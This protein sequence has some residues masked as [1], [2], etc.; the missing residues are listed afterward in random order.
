V[1]VESVNVGSPETVVLGTRSV[2]TGIGK[3]AVE[4]AFVGRLGLAG[5]TVAD[6]KHHGGPDQAVYLYTRADYAWW[7]E[8]LGRRLEPGTFGENL[9]L[10]DLNREARPGDRLRIGPVL[11]ELTAPRVP[12]AVFAHRMADR[13]WVKRFRDAERPGAYARVLEEG[14]VSVGDAIEWIPAGKPH[15]TLVELFRLFYDRS[16]P[17]ASLRRAMGAPVAIRERRELEKRL[18]KLSA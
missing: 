4:R 6:Q 16:A 15:P 1:L 14:Q 7:E 3:I 9:T 11:L 12:C 10:S 17:A 18:Q 13:G 5:D 2:E 8:E